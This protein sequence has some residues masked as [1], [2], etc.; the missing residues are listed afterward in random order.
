LAS[1][2]IFLLPAFDSLDLAVVSDAQIQMMFS[3]NLASVTDLQ[4]Y[5]VNGSLTVELDAVI[6]PVLLKASQSPLNYTMTPTLSTASAHLT[7]TITF[8]M[9]LVF[10]VVA[11][12][13]ILVQ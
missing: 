8:S 1:G 6:E 7:P 11:I 9:I 12:I 13:S 3:L 10:V 4:P 2:L 5:I